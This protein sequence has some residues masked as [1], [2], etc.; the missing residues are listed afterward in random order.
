MVTIDCYNKNPTLPK[1]QAAS[2]G[3]K[4]VDAIIRNVE[5]Y[6]IK[7]ATT[8]VTGVF[9]G[10]DF[11]KDEFPN[12]QY[13]EYVVICKFNDE[14]R[15]LNIYLLDWN[16]FL[17]HKSWR[18]RTKGWNLVITKELIIDCDAIV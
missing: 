14:N 5:R 17:K 1:L 13:F 8:N 10:L 6:T 3:T 11:G 12:N 7:S 4:N 9:T 15:L 2:V 18:S 16:S